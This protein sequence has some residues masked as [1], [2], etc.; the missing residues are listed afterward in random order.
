ML[1]IPVK[2]FSC[3]RI[4]NRKVQGVTSIADLNSVESTCFD[5]HKALNNTHATEYSKRLGLPVLKGTE[6]QIVWAN[7]IRLKIVNELLTRL[8]DEFNTKDQYNKAKERLVKTL[9]KPEFL[10][11]AYWINNRYNNYGIKQTLLRRAIGSANPE[12]AQL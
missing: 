3:G 12:H 8:I 5:C 4:F 11:A 1:T 6:K 9:N 10:L 7:P 2:C